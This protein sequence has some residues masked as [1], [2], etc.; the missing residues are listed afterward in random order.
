MIRL[1][2]VGVHWRAEMNIYPHNHML[3]PASHF[4]WQSDLLLNR[5][6]I[7]VSVFKILEAEIYPWRCLGF[8]WVINVF[9]S[10]INWFYSVIFN[11][12]DSVITQSGSSGREI[13]LS[14]DNAIATQL[15]ITILWSYLDHIS[16]TQ[17]EIKCWWWCL[18]QPVMSPL[19]TSIVPLT[20]HIFLPK[21]QHITTHWS[22]SQC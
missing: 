18:Y 9:S 19:V 12:N 4:L 5:N 1:G 2:L 7:E 10:C 6:M 8:S 3:W 16:L 20:I 13:W 22:H 15:T 11:R 14:I 21:L 17:P